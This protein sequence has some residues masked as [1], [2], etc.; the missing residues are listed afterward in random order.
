MKQVLGIA[1][2]LTVV[3]ASLAAAGAGEEKP[4]MQNSGDKVQV[5]V[6]PGK[7]SAHPGAR[8]SFKVNFTIEPK[9]H[10]YAHEDS[11]FIGIDLVPAEAFPLTD[12]K[13]DY[14]AGHEGEFFGEQ[15]VILEGSDTVVATGTVPESLAPGTYALDLALTVQACDDKI[16]LAPAH[17]PVAVELA[18][19]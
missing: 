15:V 18:V 4:K 13:I 16:C 11:M 14:P 9:W 5:S 1:L 6:A 10:L 3:A 19:Q 8:V 2:L 7:L 12:L 17:L